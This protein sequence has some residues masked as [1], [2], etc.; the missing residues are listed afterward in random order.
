M[1]SFP[2]RIYFTDDATTLAS[3]ND[4]D[5]T[6]QAL[7]RHIQAK[8]TE[9]FLSDKLCFINLDNVWHDGSKEPPHNGEIVFINHLGCVKHIVYRKEILRWNNDIECCKIIVWAYL[10]DIVPQSLTKQLSIE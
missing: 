10:A 3:I 6:R 4:L 1:N 9:A 5:A 7:N 8:D 2:T